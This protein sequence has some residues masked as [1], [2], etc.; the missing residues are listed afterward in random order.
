MWHA[1]SG[2][3]FFDRCEMKIL[4]LAFTLKI[5]Q[6]VDRIRTKSH[7]VHFSSVCLL[8]RAFSIWL[9]RRWI[10]LQSVCFFVE[11]MSAHIGFETMVQFCGLTR[12]TTLSEQLTVELLL[13]LENMILKRAFYY[14]LSLEYGVVKHLNQ[15]SLMRLLYTQRSLEHTIGNAINIMSPLTDSFTSCN[16]SNVLLS[17]HTLAALKFI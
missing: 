15:E 9:R 13:I 5:V 16:A 2:P 12:H 1:R 4:G 6:G 7:Y 14:S 8:H 11:N 3:I 17:T 10:T